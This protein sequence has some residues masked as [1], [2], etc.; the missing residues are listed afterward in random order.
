MFLPPLCKSPSQG[1]YL[2][3]DIGGDIIVGNCD[4]KCE[5]CTES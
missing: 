1:N 5:S 4:P 3:T 2:E